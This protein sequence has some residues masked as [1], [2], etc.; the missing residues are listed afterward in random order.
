M[1]PTHGSP[2]CRCWKCFLQDN[3]TVIIL[4]ALVIISLGMTIAI[5]HEKSLPDDYAKW[6]Q[7][8]TAGILSGLMLA[9][10]RPA[11]KPH[12]LAPG[13]TE[14]TLRQEPPVSASQPKIEIKTVPETTDPNVQEKSKT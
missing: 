14:A 13:T 7:G 3:F 5:M 9:M 6:A 8:F 4:F 12:P 11:E 10:N 1:T 2:T